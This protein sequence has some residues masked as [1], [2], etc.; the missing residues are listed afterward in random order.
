MEEDIMFHHSE[1]G[2]YGDALRPYADLGG[3]V[4]EEGDHWEDLDWDALDEWDE[5]S[6]KDFVANAIEVASRQKAELER[7]RE[8]EVL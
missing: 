6:W 3:Y 8:T 4:P 1:L 7:W 5:D 2:S